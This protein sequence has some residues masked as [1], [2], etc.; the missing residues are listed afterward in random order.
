[1]GGISA[2]QEGRN[3]WT[4]E[5]KWFDVP[6]GEFPSLSSEDFL[7]SEVSKDFEKS[8]KMSPYEKGEIG[9][10]RA[11]AEFEA[12]GGVVL[13]REVTV[14]V[15]G[16]QNRFDF[17]E[18]KDGII[19]FFEVKNGPKAPPTINQRINIPKLMTKEANFIPVGNNAADIKY[20]KINVLNKTPYKGNFKIIYKHYY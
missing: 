11:M 8:I 9:V 16:V 4:G 7:P 15:G 3:F 13:K 12:D 20:L 17:V 18:E 10:R 14:E 1:M 5:Q 6:V 2:Y 19:H